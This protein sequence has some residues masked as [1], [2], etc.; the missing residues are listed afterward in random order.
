MSQQQSNQN[1]EIINFILE[2]QKQQIKLSK[3]LDNEIENFDIESFQKNLEETSEIENISSSQET[4]TQEKINYEQE[5][6]NFYKSLFFFALIL[7][8]LCL[9]VT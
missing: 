8:G 2:I 5:M 9:L 6:L 1:T 4:I 7:F 3:F